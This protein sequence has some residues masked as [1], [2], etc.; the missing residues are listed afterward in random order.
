MSRDTL[1]I[2][3]V[4][5]STPREPLIQAEP[6]SLIEL[7]V[8]DPLDIS[9]VRSKNLGNEI[10]SETLPYRNRLRVLETEAARYLLYRQFSLTPNPSLERDLVREETVYQSIEPNRQDLGRILEPDLRQRSYE[11]LPLNESRGR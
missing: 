8:Q 7:Q 5:E 11:P 4:R 3:T 6:R 2:T 1:A 9:A 10:G